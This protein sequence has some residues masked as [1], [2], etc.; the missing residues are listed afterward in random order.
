MGF[1]IAPATKDGAKLRFL[2]SGPPGSGKT[3]SLLSMTEA[4]GF[5]RRVVID[6]EHGSAS[7]YADLFSFDTLQLPDPH[8]ATYVQAIH[9]CEDAGYDTIVV[10][11]LT[12]AWQA[13]LELVDAWAHSH[14]G[15]SHGAWRDVSPLWRD[16][17]DTIL[18]SPAH[19]MCSARAKTET[20]REEYEDRGRTKTRIIQLGLASIL[21][22]GAEHEFDVALM[23]DGD[24]VAEVRKSRC[25]ELVQ[26]VPMPGAE[27]GAMLLA[28]VTNNTP[29]RTW[30]TDGPSFVAALVG[31]VPD[32]VD[33][34]EAGGVA[35]RALVSLLHSMQR[36][37]PSTM[38][39]EQR[40]GLLHWLGAAGKARWDAAVA[41]EVRRLGPPDEDPNNGDETCGDSDPADQ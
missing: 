7:K 29:P 16:L 35:E 14:K 1:V 13:C 31:L 37:A 27:L 23:L 19:V 40:D 41:A 39:P 5:G 34:A 10:D 2:L 21:R 22:D 12:H 38:R 33:L 11:G 32:S 28:W 36:G 15:D 9:A 18:R 24:H 4:P 17:L 25:R 26:P 8:P 6:S 30:E 20:V 3:Y